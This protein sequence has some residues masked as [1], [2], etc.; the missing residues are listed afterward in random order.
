MVRSPRTSK[1]SEIWDAAAMAAVTGAGQDKRL[2][3]ELLT[4]YG[5]EQR[6]QNWI[7]SGAEDQTKESQ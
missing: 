4:D 5:K 7:M 6:I 2:G 1:V 3:D